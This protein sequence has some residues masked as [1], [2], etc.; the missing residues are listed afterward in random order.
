M[1]IYNRDVARIFSQLADLLEIEEAN[2]FRVRVYRNAAQTVN[3]LPRSIGELVEQEEELSKLPGTGKDL[4]GKIKEFVAT[5]SLAVLK[6][7]EQTTPPKL[8]NML[9]LW[10]L[11][12]RRVRILHE[13][14]AIDS[15][16]DALRKVC[17]AARTNGKDGC[18]DGT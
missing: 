4:A 5:V 1:P 6:E 8:A 10:R 2:A 11:G 12:P 18:V 14:L 7:H 16:A 13:Q 3:D 9:K 15:L 17:A